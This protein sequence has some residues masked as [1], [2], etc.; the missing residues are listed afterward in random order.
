MT[1]K[2]SELEAKKLIIL[3]YIIGSLGFSIKFTHNFFQYLTPLTLIFTTILIFLFHQDSFKVKE[4]IIFSFVY[5]FT[6]CI[7]VAGVQTGAV[8]GNYYYGIGLGPKLFD[9]PLMIGINW[10]FLSYITASISNGLINPNGL[11]KIVFASFLMLF[12]DVVVEL[13][14]DFLGMWYWQSS[15]IPIQNYVV[16]FFV[17]FFIQSIYYVAKIRFNNPLSSLVYFS[18]M[19]F[20]LIVFIVKNFIYD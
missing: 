16:W 4:I 12:Y 2:I 6:F 3:I 15:I 17:S 11:L 7:E 10:L 1:L 8:F 20:L 18:Q 14:A 5:L 9:T 19:L 13:V